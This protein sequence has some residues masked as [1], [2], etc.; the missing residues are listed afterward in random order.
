MYSALSLRSSLHAPPAPSLSRP[1]S[2]FHLALGYYNV[3]MPSIAPNARIPAQTFWR[4]AHEVEQQAKE[5]LKSPLLVGRCLL[6]SRERMDRAAR[7]AVIDDLA[8]SRSS[9][10]PAGGQP[11]KAVSSSTPKLQFGV[12]STNAN[13]PFLGIS[14]IGNLDPLYAHDV[15]APHIEIQSL[16]T[17]TRQRKGGALLLTWILRGQ[18][19][20][21]FAYD[22]NGFD[23]DVMDKFRRGIA[24]TMDEFLLTRPARL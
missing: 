22:S 13:V 19:Y 18:L 10:L 23:Y 12:A 4:R 20:L 3:V 8:A 16:S 9:S 15:F 21:N 5:T 6:E 7:W 11:Q 14:N 24:V 2:D 1:P 17:G